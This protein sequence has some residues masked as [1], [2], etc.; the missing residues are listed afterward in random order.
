MW[1]GISGLFDYKQRNLLVESWGNGVETILVN[2]RYSQIFPGYVNVDNDFLGWNNDQQFDRASIMTAYTPI[3]TDLHDNVNQRSLS[4][5]LGLP[6]DRV[7][8]YTIQQ[9]QSSLIG[10]RTLIQLEGN[11]RDQ[12]SNP[13]EANLAELFKYPKDVLDRLQN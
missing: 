9:M 10:A 4:A 13:T 1:Y 7:S 11:L 8:A 12:H 2:H 3:F 5:T 6:V